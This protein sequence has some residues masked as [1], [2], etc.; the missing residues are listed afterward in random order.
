MDLP[1]MGPHPG[2]QSLALSSQ[3]RGAAGAAPWGRSELCGPGE[4]VKCPGGIRAFLASVH[5]SRVP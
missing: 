1:L 4:N 2:P 5:D 3:E